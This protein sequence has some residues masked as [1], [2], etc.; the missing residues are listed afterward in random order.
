MSFAL[1]L[2]EEYLLAPTG[3]TKRVLRSAVRGLVPDEVI[4]RREKVGFETPENDWLQGLDVSDRRIANGLSKFE[5]LRPHLYRSPGG[6]VR[7]ALKWRLA[8]LGVWAH[9]YL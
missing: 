1:S 7:S 3:E 2:P 6:N 8:S 5:W 9:Q 4:D